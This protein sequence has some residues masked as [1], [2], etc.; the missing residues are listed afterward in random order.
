MNTACLTGRILRGIG[1]LYRI[2]PA[3]GEPVLAS[4]RGLLRKKGMAPTAGDWVDYQASGDPDRPWR[5]M[6]IHPRHNYLVRPTVAN[7][8]GLFIVLSAADP[9]P[10]F[11]L[12]DKLLALCKIHQI[13]PWIC[14]TKTDL[15][16]GMTDILA[17][18][19]PVGCHLLETSP[20]DESGL[21]G[22]KDWL[23]GRTAC[24]AGQSGVG[25]ST[26]LNRLCG[27]DIMPVGDLSEKIGRGRHTTREVV[28][29]P[30]AGGYLADT[31]GFS[32]LELDELG[33][34]GR[35]LPLGYPE[36]L[37]AAEHCR[38]SGCRHLGELGCAVPASG[39][40]PERLAR[41]RTLRKQLDIMGPNTPRR[42]SSDTWI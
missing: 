23:A 17:S 33:V 30:C 2:A 41:Y 35:D 13:E 18:Y 26:L 29:F 7:L 19:R 20:E 15:S 9:P 28:F 4:A 5:I 32:S 22:L 34:D 8:D 10:D 40:D 37:E 42:S 11:F 31:P 27:E 3:A 25:K 39:I 21:A 16:D 24:L 14:L 12:A 6:T 36:M 1:G 38:F